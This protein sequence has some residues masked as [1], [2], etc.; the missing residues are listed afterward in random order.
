MPD[1]KKII[2][3]EDWKSQVQAE[4]EA[5]KRDQASN[6]GGAQQG[7][8]ND[9]SWPPASFDLLLTT[10]ITEAMV[11]LGQLPHPVTGKSEMRANQARYFIDTIELLRDKTKGNLDR[12]EEL[13]LENALHQL[14]MAYLAVGQPAA[15]ASGPT[16]ED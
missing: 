15:A 14:R 12:E 9:P 1:D 6:H 11:A 2:I 13:S 16:E 7:D 4:K 8:S 3:D 5:L 10:L